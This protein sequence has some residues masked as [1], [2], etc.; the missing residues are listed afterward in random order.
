MRLRF[1][2]VP[3]TLA[4][5]W[6]GC[7]IYGPSLLVTS[8]AGDDAALDVDLCE[9]AVVPAAPGGS[10]LSGPLRVLDAMQVFTL[11]ADAGSSIGFDLDGVCTCQGG[12]ESCTPLV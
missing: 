10:N 8:D 5:A 3:I 9:H 4:V 7:S 1:A 2:A 12:G 11:G 6:Y